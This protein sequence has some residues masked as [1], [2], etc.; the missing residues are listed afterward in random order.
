MMKLTAFSVGRDLVLYC[1]DIDGLQLSLLH[2]GFKVSRWNGKISAK[3][4][5][6]G[7]HV[8]IYP[9]ESDL[10]GTADDQLDTRFILRYH[11]DE[12]ALPV[13]R[14]RVFYDRANFARFL[15]QFLGN[16]DGLCRSRKSESESGWES[17]A[18]PKTILKP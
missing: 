8:E 2:L 10:T 16:G 4:Y 11:Q 12:L 18:S 3:R 13:F 1:N 9:S 6:D 5:S 15:E 17:P 14:H 7:M